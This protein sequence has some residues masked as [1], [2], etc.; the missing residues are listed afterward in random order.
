M[1]GFPPCDR[2]SAEGR[3]AQRR[4]AGSVA[5][6]EACEAV[7]IK[8]LR[9]RLPRGGAGPRAGAENTVD[10]GGAQWWPSLVVKYAQRSEGLCQQL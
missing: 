1:T 2:I 8:E 6:T 5:L 10:R 4:P 7:L 9:Q 3:I